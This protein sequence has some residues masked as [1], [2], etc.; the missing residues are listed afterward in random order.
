MIMKNQSIPSK[1]IDNSEFLLRFQMLCREITSLDNSSFNKECVK[2]RLRDSAYSSFKD[3]Y[4]TKLAM[5]IQHF[6]DRP[7]KLSGVF[8]KA[9]PQPPCLFFFLLK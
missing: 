4:A 6:Q 7:R 3:F 5:N 9:F 8:T 1:A 2:S